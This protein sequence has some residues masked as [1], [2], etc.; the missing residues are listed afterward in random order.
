[1]PPSAVAQKCVERHSLSP[2]QLVR[3]VA[4]LHA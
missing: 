2:V 1:M 3:Q 4:P